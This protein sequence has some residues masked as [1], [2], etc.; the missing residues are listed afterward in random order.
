M[1]MILDLGHWLLTPA[2]VSVIAVLVVVAYAMRSAKHHD[3]D[4]LMMYWAGLY[5]LV[6][7]LLGGR[8]LIILFQPV[9]VL[10]HSMSLS[11]LLE[12]NRAVM[13]GFLG[14]LVMAAGYLRYKR[15]AVLQIADIAVPAVAL[16][17]V[18]ARIGCYL[19]GDDFGVVS[20]V[21][22]ALQFAEGTDAYRV[23]LERGWIAPGAQASLAVHPTQLYHALVGLIGF[24]F[25]SRMRMT[26]PGRRLAWALLL[27]GVTRFI[28][29]FYRDD[30]GEAAIDA[31]QWA[32]LLFI[33]LGC[34]LWWYQRI[35]FPRRQLTVLE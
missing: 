19:N 28:I 1:D 7:A 8:L 27:Y 14:A 32:C 34:L 29:Q 26:W 13:G 15:L 6:G 9:A 18:V 22:W 5:G 31:N 35:V 24:V 10:E 3:I 11:M 30:H 17:Y 2:T 4:P 25:L 21:P 16:G 23:Q 20:Q 12:G 33:L